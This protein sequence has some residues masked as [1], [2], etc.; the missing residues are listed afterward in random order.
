MCL[1]CV[2]LR[3]LVSWVYGIPAAIQ[4]FSTSVF[5]PVPF[6]GHF[7]FSLLVLSYSNVL[8]FALS[9]F[10]FFN[11]L[12]AHLVLNEKQKGVDLYG[13]GRGEEPGG[14][15]G[16]ETIIGIYEKNIFSI[17]EKN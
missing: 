12:E 5:V 7:S 13:K 4:W 15:E 9:H 11:P 17:K 16:G 3:V 8:V 6:L 14:I 2:L 10:I 1:L